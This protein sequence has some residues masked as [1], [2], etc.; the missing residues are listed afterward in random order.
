MVTLEQRNYFK[1]GDIV[2]FFGP[3]KEAIEFVIPDFYNEEN[4]LIDVARH[5]KEIIRF[6][7]PVELEKFD[8]IRRKLD[9]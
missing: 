5:P 4:E 6:K 9:K 8:M 2:E 1:K 7:C 3:N